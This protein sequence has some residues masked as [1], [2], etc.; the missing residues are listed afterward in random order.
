M[1]IWKFCKTLLPKL[2]ITM[3][4]ACIQTLAGTCSQKGNR[5]ANV[6][7]KRKKENVHT[8]TECTHRTNFNDLDVILCC[9]LSTHCFSQ[10]LNVIFMESRDLPGEPTLAW[11]YVKCHDGVTFRE[12]ADLC[13]RTA[14]AHQEC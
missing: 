4:T 3:L 10:E 2:I 7:P 6:S 9:E 14:L 12:E 13:R 8:H 1:I 5:K 11:K